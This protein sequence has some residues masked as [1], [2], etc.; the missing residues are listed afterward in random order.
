MSYYRL[1]YLIILLIIIM[2]ININY[3][4][5]TQNF[6]NN[7]NNTLNKLKFGHNLLDKF[8]M[9]TGYI[10][11]NHGSFGATCKDSFKAQT[12]YYVQMEQSCDEWIRGKYQTIQVEVRRRVAKYVN[13]NENELVLVENAS[14]AVSSVLRSLSDSLPLVKGD[15]LIHMDIAYAMVV[16]TAAYLS[17]VKGFTVINIPINFPISD[18][19]AFIQPVLDVIK[20]H[21]KSIKVACFDHISSFP[22]AILPIKKLV[23]ICK[24]NGTLVLVD[25]AHV[26]GQIPVNVLD[27]G[28]DFYLSNAHKWL[29]SPKGTAMLWVDKKWHSIIRPL[30]ISSAGEFPDDWPKNYE[31]IGTRDYSNYLS[32]SSAFDFRESLGDKEIME[33]IH[34]LAWNG[35]KILAEIFQTQ[36]Q[37]PNEKLVGAMVGIEVPCDFDTAMTVQKILLS[38]YDTYIQIIAYKNKAFVRISGQ[39]YL[40]L[41]DFRVMA[42]LFMEILNEV[43]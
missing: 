42:N 43:R 10:N 31:Y 5:T 38:K 23:Q 25:G 2:N 36:L 6:E 30:I 1:K 13:A 35:A 22:T 40:E 15:I 32:I 24:D 8:F 4:I 12:D 18:E 41:E 9:R 11:F 21:G 34:D 39:I 19:D 28:A 37:T 14:T 7:Q 17:R 20:Q 33:Y 16:N 29:Y 26:M 27:I 3:G